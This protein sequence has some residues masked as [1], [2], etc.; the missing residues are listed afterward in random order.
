MALPVDVLASV[1]VSEE[2][3]IAD[4]AGTLAAAEC[5]VEQTA[6]NRLDVAAPWGAAAAGTLEH[7]WQELV[8]FLRAWQ[9]DHHDV[10]LRVEDVRFARSTGRLAAADAA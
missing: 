6:P 7:A 4:L 2:R 3:A 5:T 8:F 9:A 1:T 10:V